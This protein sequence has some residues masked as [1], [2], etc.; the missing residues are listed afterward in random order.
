[1]PALDPAVRALLEAP[2]FVHVA[3]LMPDGSPHSVAVWAAVE[4]EHPCFFTQASSQKARNLARDARVALSV[5]DRENPYR[6]ARLRGR[7]TDA[8]EG[9]A[10]LTV[11]DRI[12]ECYTGQPFPLRSGTV[13]LVE[14]EHATVAELPFHD[15]PPAR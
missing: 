5:V 15:T 10:A 3:T 6:S 1:M 9:D 14:V 7:V 2:N 12:A 11:I 8:L 4:G 13:Y